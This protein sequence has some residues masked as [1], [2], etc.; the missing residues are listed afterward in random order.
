MSIRSSVGCLG[1][2]VAMAVGVSVSALAQ[3]FIMNNVT[4]AT[5]SYYT[6]ANYAGGVAPDY[7]TSA[8]GLVFRENEIG[9]RVRPLGFAILIR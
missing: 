1:I 5:P 3:E 8:Y 4:D 6:A 7:K 9:I 2:A